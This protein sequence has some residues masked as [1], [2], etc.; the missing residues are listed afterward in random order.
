[1]ERKSVTQ[2]TLDD[3]IFNN[4]VDGKGESAMMLLSSNNNDADHRTPTSDTCAT[5]DYVPPTWSNVTPQHDRLFSQERAMKHDVSDAG[6]AGTPTHRVERRVNTPDP[7]TPTIVQHTIRSAS[8]S[9]DIIKVRTN[10]PLT[11][12]NIVPARGRRIIINKRKKQEIPLQHSTSSIAKDGYHG[13]LLANK[14]MWEEVFL[15]QCIED[16]SVTIQA[17]VQNEEEGFNT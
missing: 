7:H 11:R 10:S 9:Q 16:R 14:A 2:F 8:G 12:A 1:M 3:L 5:H 15:E 4:I 6:K 17:Q 13:W